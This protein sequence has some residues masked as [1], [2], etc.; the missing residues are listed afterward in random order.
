MKTL[1]LTRHAKTEQLSFN[2]SKSDFERELKPRGYKDSKLVVRDLISRHIQPSL[3]ISSN[4]VRAKQTTDIFAEFFGFDKQN[5]ILE[6]FLYGGY[7]PSEFLN[8]LSQFRH[9]YKSIMIVGHNPEIE[10]IAISLTGDSYLHFPTTGTISISFNV[11]NWEKVRAKEGKI[12][13]L[14]TPKMFK[15]TD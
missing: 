5:I 14:I 1:I 13:F 2:S 4:A 9:K 8:Y 3:I 15:G 6:P 11:D 10:R 12:E 7:A